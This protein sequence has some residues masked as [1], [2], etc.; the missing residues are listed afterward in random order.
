MFSVMVR[1]RFNA[2]HSVRIGAAPRETPHGHDWLV[3]VEVAAAAL[4]RHGLVI[5]FHRVERLLDECLAEFRGALLNDLPAFADADPTTERV[6]ETIHRR[7]EQKLGNAS[8]RGRARA[9]L[10]RTT[11]WETDTCGATYRPA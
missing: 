5:D 10:A 4:D 3:E 1:T 2:S 6:A 7:L 8:G 9:R 11:V